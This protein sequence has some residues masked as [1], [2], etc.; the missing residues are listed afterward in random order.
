MATF[1]VRMAPL[2][3]ESFRQWTGVQGQLEKGSSGTQGAHD[4]GWCGT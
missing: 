2:L 3:S 1:C 4:G